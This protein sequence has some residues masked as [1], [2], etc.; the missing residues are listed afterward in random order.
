[1][2]V[3]NFYPIL[4]KRKYEKIV[5]FTSYCLF[6]FHLF[7]F[8]RSLA[9]DYIVML[10]VFIVVAFV[11]ILQVYLIYLCQCYSSNSDKQFLYCIIN[12][13]SSHVLQ[14]HCDTF[15]YLFF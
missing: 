6:T 3:I 8:L 5:E 14:I 2:K 7:H 12:Y 15:E 1:M 4:N 13:R 10:L 11:T 9:V